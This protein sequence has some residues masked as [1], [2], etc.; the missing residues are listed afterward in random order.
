M[1]VTV[2]ATG[3]RHDWAWSISGLI[4]GP[5]GWEEQRSTGDGREVKRSPGQVRQALCPFL[6]SLDS[7]LWA[8][9]SHGGFTR[10]I[11]Q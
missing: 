9:R 1:N 4:C 3:R 6:R 11:T 2:G 8:R 7:I 10:G 5:S